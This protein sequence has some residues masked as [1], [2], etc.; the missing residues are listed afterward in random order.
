[1]NSRHGKGVLFL[2]D[3]LDAL[4]LSD[5]LYEIWDLLRFNLWPE[6]GIIATTTTTYDT[7]I[8]D[9]KNHFGCS[10][11]GWK[12]CHLKGFSIADVKKEIK[13]YFGR[14]FVNADEGQN[15]TLSRHVS[16]LLRIFHRDV[17]ETTHSS[18][19]LT[20][21][22]CEAFQIASEHKGKVDIQ[23]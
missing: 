19:I 16:N 22:L 21:I 7:P 3:N 17:Y 15:L 11:I 1:M 14:N 23:V 9:K 18:P 8:I 2:L 5:D 4:E 10:E 6:C 12:Q 20:S 13:R